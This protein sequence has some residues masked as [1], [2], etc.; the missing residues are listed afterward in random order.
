M[1]SHVDKA[2]KSA[3]AVAVYTLEKEH[4]EATATEVVEVMVAS[5][6]LLVK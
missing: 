1:A 4:P 5:I 6:K 2:C 3:S